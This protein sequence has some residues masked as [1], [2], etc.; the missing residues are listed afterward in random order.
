MLQVEP[1]PSPTITMMP[2]LEPSPMTQDLQERTPPAF[3][4]DECFQDEQELKQ[5]VQYYIGALSTQAATHIRR[6]YRVVSCV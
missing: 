6:Q 5:A 2:T 3:Y 1:T 4:M